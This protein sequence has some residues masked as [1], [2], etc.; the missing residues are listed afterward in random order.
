MYKVPEEWKLSD[1]LELSNDEKLKWLYN[2]VK[3]GGG[4]SGLPEVTADDNGDVLTVVEGAWAKAEPGGG[5][6]ENYYVDFTA[7]YDS[8]QNTYTITSNETGSTIATAINAGK[9]IV[10]RI[11]WPTAECQYVYANGYEVRATSGDEA[12][13]FAFDFVDYS[14]NSLVHCYI[15]WRFKSGGSWVS[16]VSFYNLSQ[17]T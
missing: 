4:G 8:D 17:S 10:G 2:G 12:Y 5:G 7:T 15:F 11:N 9:N 1:F 3:N 14:L 13:R 16:Q 6:A